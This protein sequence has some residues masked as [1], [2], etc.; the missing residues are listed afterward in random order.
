MYVYLIIFIFALSFIFYFISV[1]P[2]SSK[3]KLED[4]TNE[5]NEA[6]KY[7]DSVVGWLTVEGTITM[8]GYMLI[9]IQ[10]VITLVIY[11]IM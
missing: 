9:L 4:M 5:I 8:L 7:G 11:H 10:E 6:K 3:L 1:K 2:K